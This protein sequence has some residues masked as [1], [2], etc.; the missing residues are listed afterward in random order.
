MFIYEDEAM[1]TDSFVPFGS[2][3]DRFHFSHYTDE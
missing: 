2:G 3:F 1:A